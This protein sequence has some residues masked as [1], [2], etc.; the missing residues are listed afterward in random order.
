MSLLPCTPV[1]LDMDM[2]GQLTV[3][4]KDKLAENFLPLDGVS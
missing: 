1:H 4:N 3:R 2:K